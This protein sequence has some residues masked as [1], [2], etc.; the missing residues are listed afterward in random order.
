MANKL[1][2]YTKYYYKLNVTQENRTFQIEY[3]F[4][5]SF[6]FTFDNSNVNIK[7]STIY[8]STI[9]YNISLTSYSYKINEASTFKYLILAELS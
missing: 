4:T 7:S 5:I 8:L 1:L 2:C 9:N 6:I 3:S